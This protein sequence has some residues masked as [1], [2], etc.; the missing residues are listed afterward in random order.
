MQALI[1]YDRSTIK[2]GD[3]GHPPGQGAGIG[4]RWT[5]YTSENTPKPW[6]NQ[7]GGKRGRHFFGGER[8]KGL[9]IFRPVSAPSTR[10]GRNCN[11]HDIPGPLGWPSQASP[12]AFDV[13]FRETPPDSPIIPYS[14]EL[15][16][17]GS[18][19]GHSA[20]RFTEMPIVWGDWNFLWW[21]VLF[22]RDCTGICIAYMTN[23]Q[24]GASL[25]PVFS[26]TNIRT[27][28]HNFYNVGGQLM[29]N[30]DGTSLWIGEYATSYPSGA[31]SVI[32][33]GPGFVGGSWQD[34]WEDVPVFVET[35]GSNLSSIVLGHGTLS[36][37][38]IIVPNA[39]AAEIDG[40]GGGGPVDPTPAA[41]FFGFL[42]SGA[43][44]GFASPDRIRG[45]AFKAGASADINAGGLRCGG[46]LLSGDTVKFKLELYR[47]SGDPALGGLPTALLGVSN[48]VTLAGDFS[49]RWQSVT[50]TPAPHTDLDQWYLLA[51]HGGGTVGMQIYWDTDAVNRYF[52]KEATYVSGPPDP[53]GV[54]LTTEPRKL[55]IYVN[56]TASTTV[57]T[58]DIPFGMSPGFKILERSDSDRAAELDSV[59]DLGAKFI[60]LDCLDN[61]TWQQ[62]FQDTAD[63]AIARRLQVRAVLHGTAG[64]LTASQAETFARAQAIKWASRGITIFEFCNEP[65]L[66]GW[67]PE[68]YADACVGFHAGLKDGNPNATAMVGALWKW[69]DVMPNMTAEFFRRMCQRWV[70]QG[71]T[72]F[73]FDV[74]SV[75]LY[76][77]PESFA[78]PENNWWQLDVNGLQTIAGQGSNL[79]GNIRSVMSTYGITGKPVISSESGHKITEPPL[80]AGLGVTAQ[81]AADVIRNQ[82]EAVRAGRLSGITIYAV[83]DD[84]VT[85]HGMLDGAL[86]ERPAYAV[87]QQEGALLQDP[88]PVP[89]VG[90]VLGGARVIGGTR[91]VGG[92]GRRVGEGGGGG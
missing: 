87:C 32:D 40:G 9:H 92:V 8:W 63:A 85:G 46:R 51:V 59:V 16:Y 41:P 13:N 35:W 69:T 70:A 22:K 88:L 48:E 30:G 27:I 15:K 89:G 28:N 29:Q 12:V 64:V 56:G 72:T 71:V 90:R 42:S 21:D 37:S 73:P 57:P 66:Q 44:Q 47:M 31:D 45:C 5:V 26:Y 25:G 79:P 83:R 24:R 68:Q 10:I 18:C 38:S 4:A 78:A 75:H 61:A 43:Q 65:D 7:P 91:R 84:D 39:I 86:A 17:G 55:S 1:P 6:L 3:T 49:E 34:V 33:N 53:Y 60:R 62:E 81:E 77:D 20:N 82:F 76:D 2:A 52:F 80:G 19:A 58:W 67:T 54:P 23:A 14:N 74:L 36:S 50:F 11:F